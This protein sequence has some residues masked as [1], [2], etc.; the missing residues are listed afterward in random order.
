MLFVIYSILKAKCYMQLEQYD[1]AASV[2]DDIDVHLSIFVYAKETNQHASF[3]KLK[4]DIYKKCGFIDMAKSNYLRSYQMDPYLLSVRQEL[5]ELGVGVEEKDDH[6]N[7]NAPL[8]QSIISLSSQHSCLLQHSPSIPYSLSPLYFYI[9][10]HHYYDFAQYEKARLAFT[11]LLK[12]LPW[13]REGID[14]YSSV[15]FIEKREQELTALLA[16]ERRLM[17]DEKETTVIQANLSSLK[18]EGGVISILE[19][20]TQRYPSYTYARQLLAEEHLLRDDSEKAI[21]NFRIAL[22]QAPHDHRLWLGM[23]DCYVLQGKYAFARCHYEECLRLFPR[24]VSGLYR[25]NQSFLQE[26]KYT[27]ANES[28]NRSLGIAPDDSKLLLQKAHLLYVEAKY[29]EAIRLYER[30]MATSTLEVSAYMELAECYRNLGDTCECN[31]LLFLAARL[32]SNKHHAIMVGNLRDLFLLKELISRIGSKSIRLKNNKHG[33]LPFPLDLPLFVLFQ[34]LNH[35]TMR[36][37]KLNVYPTSSTIFP[38]LTFAS[39]TSAPE[40]IIAAANS[41]E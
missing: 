30:V 38:H 32:D 5:H 20:T 18:A 40:P 15:L 34:Q 26:E 14:R 29:Q 16:C 13:W 27:R 25:V 8:L 6:V 41:G 11:S 17:P 9:Q 3:F 2:L 22:Q 35:P 33:I 28:I 24:C 12:I 36:L 7:D 1:N 4:G 19:K 31:R 23:G 39:H 37:G 21:E 10:F